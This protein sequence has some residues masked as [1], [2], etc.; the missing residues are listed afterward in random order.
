MVLAHVL[1]PHPLTNIRVALPALIINLI[2]TQVNVLVLEHS[3]QLSK[4]LL[5]HRI[6]LLVGRVENLPF[7][8]YRVDSLIGL[9][10]LPAGSDELGEGAAE[11]VDMTRRVELGYYADTA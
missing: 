8:L 7:R 5:Q 1:R 11:R 10:V 3:L 6:Q 4:E 9:A 2:I